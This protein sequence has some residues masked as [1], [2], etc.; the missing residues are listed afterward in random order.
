MHPA[1]L[2]VAKE[3]HRLS[4][5]AGEFFFRMAASRRQLLCGFGLLFQ[6]Q[7]SYAVD[8]LN[9]PLPTTPDSV[10]IRFDSQGGMLPS[11][12]DQPLLSIRADGRLTVNGRWFGGSDRHGQLSPAALQQ[13]LR[14]IIAEKHFPS[15][16]SSQI[17]QQ[18]KALQLKD[19]R[20]LAIADAPTTQISLQLPPYSHRIAF[21]AVDMSAQQFPEVSALQDL[22]A[23]Q[24]RLKALIG[25]QQP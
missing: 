25:E 20:L 23:V 3:T 7:I 10:I 4:G 21:Y 9:Y 22:L 15:L 13:L 6:T 2:A 16:D 14:F 1:I 5:M 19:G 11:S 12:N 24:N 18:L 17:E 8:Q